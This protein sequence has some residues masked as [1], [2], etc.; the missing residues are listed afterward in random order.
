MD[1][2][3]DIEIIF[4]DDNSK[5]PLRE[6]FANRGLKNFSIY[7]TG[8]TRLWTQACARNLGIK[9]AQGEYIFNSDIDHILPK[10]AIMM[11]YDFTGDKIDF[12]REF[13]VLDC[14][15]NIRQDEKILV[16]YGLSKRRFKKYGVSRYHHVNTH[17]IKKQ[18]VEDI[19]GYP[20][21]CCRRGKHPTRDDRLFYH[22]F[23]RHCVR[24]FCEPA[25]RMSKVY[26][27]PGYKPKLFHE[28]KR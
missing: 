28:L 15:G 20:V 13:A 6:C 25:I 7:P 24:G 10:E 4:I 26:C 17:V 21:R 8:D 22:R 16:K 23:R 19:G 18:I 11:A 12:F 2:P 27:F 5:P 9:I 14:Y 3:N 1:L